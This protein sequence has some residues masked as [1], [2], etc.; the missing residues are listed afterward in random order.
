M[1][2]K[3]KDFLSIEQLEIIL[4]RYPKDPV[5]IEGVILDYLGQSGASIDTVFQL[6]QKIYTDLFIGN[7]VESG[8]ELLRC[9]LSSQE[10]AKELISKTESIYSNIPKLIEDIYGSPNERAKM[11]NKLFENPTQHLK[12]DI[13]SI[14]WQISDLHFGFLNTIDNDPRELAFMLAK[15]ASDYPNLKPDIVLISG[16]LSSMA[17][18]EEFHKFVQFCKEFEKIVWGTPSPERLLVV[19]GNHDTTW[20]SNGDADSMSLFRSIVSASNCCITP[21]G[22]SEETF[23]NGLIT[24]KR[25]A[26]N[27]EKSPPVTQVEFAQY[28][29]RFLL[30]VSGY[31]SGFIPLEFR[32]LREK[33]DKIEE[34]FLNL[35]RVDNGEVNREYLYDISCCK[36][37]HN[38]TTLGVIHHNPIQY[39]IETCLNKYAIQ[40]LETLYKIDVPL[41]LHGHVHQVD[42]PGSQRPVITGQSYALPCPTL[43]SIPSSGS[44]RGINMFFV[45]EETIPRKIWTLQWS[46]SSSTSFKPDG[47]TIKHLFRIEGKDIE[48]D[49]PIFSDYY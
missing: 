3:T 25:S 30:L 43:S 40:L 21:F 49:Y 44:S 7:N 20:L 48:V 13:K 6:N 14:I 12:A 15:I 8:K 19:P 16:D 9:F 10:S 5:N 45:G 18:K 27:M 32:L 4:K 2:K 24:V 1:I 31:F 22:P 36:N 34:N 17:G 23:A 39:G 11:I 41:L 33:A 37:D 38:A 46:I 28:G 29:L 42:D 47:A 35:L 26:S